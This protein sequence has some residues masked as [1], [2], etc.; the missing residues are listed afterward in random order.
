MSSVKLLP[1]DALVKTGP[2][3]QAHW[4]F[5]P[6]L[7]P[8][9]RLRYNL[10]TRLLAPSKVPRLLEVGYGS[11]ILLPELAGRCEELHGIDIHPHST[12]VQTR[13]AAFGVAAHL[14]EG[15]A[16]CLPYPSRTFDVVVAVSSLEFVLDQEAAS[17]EIHRVL[18]R[19]GRLI[20]VTP[21]R[22]PLADLG[23]QLLTG[24]SAK[25]DFG[26]RRE[27]LLPTLLRRFRLEAKYKSPQL[28]SVYGGFGFRPL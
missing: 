24:K 9:S 28:L 23:L 4:N 3:D 17:T 11:G 14:A 26:N 15:S 7:G 19:G 8:V 22:S 25:Q 20:V 21:L 12:E 10:L 13:L 18:T 6:I 27:Y 5:R 1:C 16:E 2:V